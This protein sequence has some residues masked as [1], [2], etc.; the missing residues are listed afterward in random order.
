MDRR[1]EILVAANQS[2]TLFGYKATTMEQ[3]AKMA[4]VGKGTI[5]TFFQNKDILFQEIVMTMIG[6]MKKQA[7]QSID[8]SASFLDNAHKILMNLLEFREVHKLYAKLVE[9][10]NALRTPQVEN[11]LIKIEHEIITFIASKIEIAINKNE[12]K[13][14]NSEHVAYLLFKAYLAFVVEWPHTHAEEL[15]EL[16]IAELFKNTLFGGLTP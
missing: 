2:F 1:H 11:V 9:E 16:T 7:E 5:Y 14:C 4:N 6:D 8:S 12:I 13:P 3:V 10:E 15:D